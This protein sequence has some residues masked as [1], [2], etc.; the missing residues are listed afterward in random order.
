MVPREKQSL[1]LKSIRKDC[2]EK[3]IDHTKECLRQRAEGQQ[4]KSLQKLKEAND[5][6]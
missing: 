5:V 2:L 6:S 3:N 1:W 4:V